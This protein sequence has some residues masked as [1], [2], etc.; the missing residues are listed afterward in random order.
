MKRTALVRRTPLRRGRGTVSAW[1][2]VVRAAIRDRDRSCVGPRVG[3]TEVCLGQMEID[4][5]RASGAL[6]KKSPSTVD[7]GALLCARHHEMK[8]NDGRRWR[9]VLLAYIDRAARR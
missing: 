1:P 8:T 7:N 5:V 4:H 6:G 2:D 9:P 3:M